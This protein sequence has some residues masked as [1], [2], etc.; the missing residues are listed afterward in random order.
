MMKNSRA[1]NLKHLRYFAEVARRGS[2]TGAASA[3]FVA[4][5]TVSTQVLELEQ[6]VGQPLFE[7]VGRRLVLT[8]AGATALEYSNSI[9]ALGDELASVLRGAARPRSMIL[10]VGVTDSVPKLLTVAVLQPVI[11]AHRAQL[12][13]ECREGPFAQLLGQ[14]AAGTLDMLLADA[15]VPATLARAIQARALSESGMSFMASR[16]LAARLARHFPASLDGAPFIAGSAQSS[17]PDQGVAAWFARNNVR[18]RMVGHIDD[19]AL[20]K[21][22]AQRGLGVIAVP[23]SIEVEVARQYH[24]GV[25]GRTSE[26]RQT[27][28]LLRA[29]ARRPHPLVAQIESAHRSVRESTH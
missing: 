1:L 26:V 3:L 23:S 12:E 29:R 14:L 18:P 10:R 7:R 9:F 21:G 15:A 11:E 27:I 2:V 6:S 28:F 13:L 25:I 20:S 17:L 22:F 16:P 24:L 4:P 19:S 8:A 5:Q